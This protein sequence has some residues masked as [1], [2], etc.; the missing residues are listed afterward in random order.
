MI[1]IERSECP[2]TLVDAP[3]TAD[4]YN[5]AAVVQALWEMQHG[6]CC[7]CERN[8]PEK[9][10]LKAVEHFA[11]KAIY[12]GLRNEWT[13]LLLACSQCNG[14]KS[15]KF[16]VILSSQDQEDKVLYVT[17]PDPGA[18]AI[19]NP[20]SVDPELHIGFDFTGVEWRDKF[21]VMMAR[22]GS[23]LGDETITTV[24]LQSEFYAKLRWNHYT[25]VLNVHYN[26]LLQ[27]VGDKNALSL[28][29]QRTTFENLMAP[30]T[31]F[32]GYARAFARSKRL[33][34][35]PISLTI[36]GG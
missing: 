35:P 23:V 10:H 14:Q 11:P 18:P 21:G 5:R 34:E 9:G 6:K 26:N 12:K 7:Y 31:E 30:G 36:P 28:S 32:A 25:K 33:Y 20:S 8:L 3:E 16:P 22:A 27:A 15:D 24:G 4:A 29:G 19:I 1:F 17:T 13:N 2:A